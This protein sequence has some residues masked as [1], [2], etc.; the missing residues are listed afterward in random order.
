MQFV[1]RERSNVMELI[2]SE[3]GQALELPDALLELAEEFGSRM[4]DA[5]ELLYLA[6]TLATYAWQTTAIV[7][8]IGAY[9]GRTTLFMAKILRL[10]GKR[11]PILSID[12]F[13]AFLPEALNPQ[14]NSAAYLQTVRAN[15]VGDV[16]LPLTAF[17]QDAA[18]VVPDTIGVL[19]VDGGHTYPV[20]TQDLAL[21]GPKVLPGGYMFID[22]YGPAYPDVV[23]AVDEYFVPNSGFSVLHKSYFVVAKRESGT[24][25]CETSA[26][27][28]EAA[29]A[30][31]KRE[32]PAPR[33]KE[34]SKTTK[35]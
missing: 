20:V 22:D 10:L 1:Q 18:P 8:E 21:Y 32:K 15:N 4:M 33:G 29:K 14:G 25:L 19:V 16:C 3:S 34:R 12:A 17:S 28:P 7:V 23:C 30:E 35:K 6:G 27:E 2:L 11:V 31:S 24:A 9:A 5:S 26:A 13:D